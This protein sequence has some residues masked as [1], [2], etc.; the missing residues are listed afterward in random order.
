MERCPFVETPFEECHVARLTS[1]VLERAIAQCGGDYQACDIYMT[2]VPERPPRAMAGEGKAALRLLL[3]DDCQA[4]RE[5]VKGLLEREG[6][7]V[8][9]EAS[10]GVEAIRMAEAVQPD[11]AI[12]D[13]RMPRRGGLHAARDIRQRCPGTRVILLTVHAEEYE[14]VMALRQGVK[15]YVVKAEAT[16]HLARAVREVARGETFVS[17]RASRVLIDAH[18]RDFSSSTPARP[19]AAAA[20]TAEGSPTP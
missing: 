6:F 11:V 1:G 18:L 8:V 19:P 14:I 13:L 12:L 9:G 20:S 2:H 17:P 16:E 3:A 5:L 7:E 4:V 15:G 10:D